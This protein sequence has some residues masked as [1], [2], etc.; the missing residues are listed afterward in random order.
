MGSLPSKAIDRLSQL[1]PWN[2]PSYDRSRPLP[3]GAV[4][5]LVTHNPRL[6]ELRQR[7]ASCTVPMAERSTHWWDDYSLKQGVRLTH[8][9]GDN[10]Y[11]WQFRGLGRNTRAKYHAYVRHIS[12]IDKYDLL[13]RL[14]E[15]GLFGC[16]TFSYPGFPLVSRDLLDSIN[17]LYFLDRYTE[18]L[19]RPG[20]TVLDIGAG[21]GRL[22]WRALGA[23]P[24]LSAYLCA[25]GVAEST[26]VCE[27]YL[28]FRHCRAEVLPLDEVD[29][30]L[31]GRRIDV[32]VN[33]H[34]FSEMTFRAIEGWLSRL[35]SHRVPW[36][37]IVPN[38]AHLLS[39]EVDGSRREF[40][41]LLSA[42]GYRLMHKEPTL[43]EDV[44]KVMDV[45]DNFFLFQR[46]TT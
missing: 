33:I 6:L 39:S 4:E 37:L 2:R 14:Q 9:R 25:D 8:F 35:A 43:P 40:G 11:L 13:T 15:D 38:T 5:E 28:R 29:E 1:L 44:R 16:W 19:R 20:M 24:L 7:Y 23:A 3:Q 31:A 17:E 18:I 41:S 22:A 32:A 12:R 42:S 46:P 45:H 10:A 21:Y 27:Y 26:F 30:R 36:L 34:S